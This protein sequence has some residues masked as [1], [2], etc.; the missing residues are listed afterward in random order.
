MTTEST[1]MPETDDQVC[2]NCRRG[3][4]RSEF[5]FTRWNEND[6]A[7]ADVFHGHLPPLLTAVLAAPHSRLLRLEFHQLLYCFACLRVY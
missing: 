7:H 5:T 4:D 1:G 2:S 3:E 6:V